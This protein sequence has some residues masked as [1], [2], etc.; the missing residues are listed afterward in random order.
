MITDD[1]HI[2]IL[3]ERQKGR[4]R[5]SRSDVRLE[6]KM[7]FCKKKKVSFNVAVLF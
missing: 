6:R 4:Q 2:H 5:N 1:T 3:E 7:G